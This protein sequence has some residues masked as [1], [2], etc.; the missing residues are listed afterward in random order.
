[1]QA[2]LSYNNYLYLCIVTISAIK[3]IQPD[4]ISCIEQL[5]EGAFG[6]VYLGRCQHMPKEGDNTMVAIK[7]L[8]NDMSDD[9]KKDF[10]RESEVLTNMEHTNIVTFYGVSVDGDTYMMIFE[11]MAK[12]DLSKY[13]RYTYTCIYP[14][15]CNTIQHTCIVGI[16][17][18]KQ[19]IT[20]VYSNYTCFYFC[21]ELTAV[22]IRY[23]R[24]L[25]V[26]I[27]YPRLLFMLRWYSRLLTLP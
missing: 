13:L 27:R 12:G 23:P 25:A 26:P 14:M 3:Q 8:K 17:T 6:R 4:F 19:F 11:Y 21:R 7:M 2:K 15:S 20:I 9:C 16:R 18:S 22:P 1:M 5:G 10:E 24:L